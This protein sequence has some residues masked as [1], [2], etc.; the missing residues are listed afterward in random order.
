MGKKID[1]PF[2][3]P[4]NYSESGKPDRGVLFDAQLL[5]HQAN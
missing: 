4:F 5:I 2:C 3:E 1:T